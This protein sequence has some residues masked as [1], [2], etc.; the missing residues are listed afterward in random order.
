MGTRARSAP[1]GRPAP[2]PHRRRRRCRHAAPQP[3]G[4][5]VPPGRGGAGPRWAAIG[6]GHEG[7]VSARQGRAGPGSSVAVRVPGGGLRSAALPARSD[8]A[9]IQRDP[10]W[11]PLGSR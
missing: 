11:S 6:T 1:P 3:S 2:P 7:G 4:P 10:S 9:C 8:A 5:R